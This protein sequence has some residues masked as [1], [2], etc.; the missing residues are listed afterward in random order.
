MR[1]TKI[2]NQVIDNQKIKETVYELTRRFYHEKGI[3]YTDDYCGCLDDY[4]KWEDWLRLQEVKNQK[5]TKIIDNPTE[6]DRL[7]SNSKREQTAMV[8]QE[9]SV[10]ETIRKVRL[11]KLLTIGEIIDKFKKSKNIN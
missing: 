2:I 3:E 8:A 6:K 10:E 1:I 9:G 4:G 11:E 7:E 5:E